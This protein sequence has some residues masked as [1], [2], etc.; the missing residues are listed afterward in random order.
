DLD[1]LIFP[2]GFGAAKNLSTFAFDGAKARVLPD[3]ERLLIE[4]H[5]AKKPI[6]LACIAP[7]IA[8][9]VFGRKGLHP[10]LTI[11]ADKDTASAIEAMGGE[12]HDV[13]P[14]EIY[15][16]EEN[17][18]VTTPCYMNDV[19][20]WVVFQGAEKM[21]EEVLRLSGNTAAV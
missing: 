12:H 11:G 16:D 3:V 17:R 21:V 13:G 8:A 5:E 7:V 14:T 15:I 10:K 4:M 1:A 18:L 2:G 6:G 9:A 19:G 20:P